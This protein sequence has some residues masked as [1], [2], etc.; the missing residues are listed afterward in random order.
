MKSDHDFRIDQAYGR[1][2]EKVL[3]NLIGHYH[4][5]AL[6]RTDE[7]TDPRIHQDF[8][9]IVLTTTIQCK[10]RTE[11]Y[12]FTC[13]DDYP[14]D[15]ILVDTERHLRM[16]GIPVDLYYSLT[17]EQ[18]RCYIRWFHSY[19]VSAP[20][21]EH[22]A[23][24][25]PASKAYWVLDECWDKRNKSHTIN[26]ACPKDKAIFVNKNDLRPALCRL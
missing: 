3:F 22:F 9:D 20:D 12:Q 11:R 19:W 4:P 18:R 14:F 21:M 1:A 23:V 25:I 6:S 26:W 15:T 10:R 8:G 17:Q 13:C 5:M 7:Y 16:E 2:F 24:I